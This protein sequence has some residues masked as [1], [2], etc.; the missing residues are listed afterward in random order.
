MVFSPTSI[1]LAL[2][3]ARAGAKGATASEMDA[4]LHTGGWA[5][6]GPG[7]NA[8]DQAIVSRDGTYTD[9]E[10]KTPFAGA[11]HRQQ[12]LRPA[13]L[14]DGAGLPRRDRRGLRCW[15]PA[16]RLP[17]GSRGRPQD[18]Q[19]VGEPAD[20]AAD[21]GAPHQPDVSDTTRLYLVNAM[22][23]KANW[24]REF[25]K[26]ATAP[27]AFARLDGSRVDVPTMTLRGGKRSRMSVA[28]AGAP[29][30]CATAAATTPT[31]AMDLIMP[32][33]LKVFEAGLTPSS[34]RG[35]PKALTRERVR[36]NEGDHAGRRRGRCGATRTARGCTCRSSASRRARS[37]VTRLPGS[38]C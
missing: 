30:S 13:R 2:G 32:T 27:K 16:R 31:P 18:H 25:D 36:L 12:H 38:G 15:R 4:V 9:D 17:G 20:R 33:D 8:L 23:L 14:V 1:A 26:E 21:P 3:M 22:Y 35:S 19:R 24:V 29:P 34:S 11:A 28:T 5:E 6:L 37:W 10:G 7:L